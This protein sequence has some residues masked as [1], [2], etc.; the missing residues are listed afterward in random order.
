VA[1]SLTHHREH[2]SEFERRSAIESIVEQVA[3]IYIFSAIMLGLIGFF[4][5]FLNLLII[6]AI[7]KNANVL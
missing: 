3:G 4:G 7:V 1:N 5:F 6:L 2:V